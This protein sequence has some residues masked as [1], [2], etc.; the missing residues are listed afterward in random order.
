[1]G[2]RRA[3]SAL[4]NDEDGR[5]ALE[6]A[7]AL[8]NAALSEDGAW[9]VGTLRFNN[10]DGRL[11]LDFPSALNETGM[12]SLR[13]GLVKN[14][15]DALWLSEDYEMVAIEAATQG[16]ELP[17]PA[18]SWTAPARGAHPKPRASA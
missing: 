8:R 7:I 15:T 12:T 14:A 9:S 6:S 10:E 5:A 2:V 4:T 13:Q 1:V 3:A 17:A 11:L 18:A 16:C